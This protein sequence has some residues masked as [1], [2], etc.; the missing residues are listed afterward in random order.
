MI[1]IDSKKYRNPFKFGTVV[2]EPY[3]FNRKDELKQIV[4]TL[5]GGNNL[6]LYAPRRYGKTSLVM[7]ALQELERDRYQCIYFDF[8]TVYSRES[9]IE[10][11]SK[12]ILS[13]QN[14]WKKALQVFSK[15]VKGIKPSVTIDEKGNPQFSIEFVE[16]KVS[17]MTLET[18]IDLPERLADKQY[19]TIIV[20][21]EFQD[22]QKL[23][24]EYFEDLMRSKIQHH[25][26]I[27]Y[28]FLGSRTHLLNDMFS[29]KNRP[30]YNSAMIMSIGALPYRETVD[31]LIRSFAD[32]GIDISESEAIYLIEKAGNIPYYIQFLA[33]EI[34]QETIHISKSITAEMIDINADKILDL[35]QD[36]YFELFDHCTAYQKKLLKAL[37]LTGQNIYSSEYGEKFRLSASSTT[38]KA[39]EGLVNSAIIEKQESEYTFPDPFFKEY[40]LRLPA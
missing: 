38:Q 27:N 5:K 40:I 24:G 20:M 8:M 30:F 32:S 34:W 13:N 31:F 10:S 35:K 39:I 17:D 1:R 29:N 4:E 36:Y 18:V 3:F 26:H 7:K 11:F 37:A 23:N 25:K 33:S 28:L 14:H 2:D 19:P 15:F 22:I 9:F 21:D 6:V 16:L 12:A